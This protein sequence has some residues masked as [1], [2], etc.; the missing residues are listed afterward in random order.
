MK[1]AQGKWGKITW[2]EH[3]M[4]SACMG[5]WWILWADCAVTEANG[6]PP[7]WGRS[8]GRTCDGAL[9]VLPR[10][11]RSLDLFNKIERRS[12]RLPLLLLAHRTDPQPPWAPR[13]SP[14]KSWAQR[15]PAHHCP[16]LALERWG[17]GREERHSRGG[18]A[19]EEQAQWR[20][21]ASRHDP[22][23]LRVCVHPFFFGKG[24]K[25]DGE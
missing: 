8:R 2:V 18:Q 17:S 9:Q 11:Y 3:M 10:V 14:G 13:K 25:K 19:R 24:Q 15:H 7:P 16:T 5:E 20:H 23:E 21:P 4:M 6:E 12:H 22:G 1:S